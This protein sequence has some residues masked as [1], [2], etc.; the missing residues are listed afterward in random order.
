MSSLLWCHSLNLRGLMLE[1]AAEPGGQMLLMHHP[2]RDYPGLLPENGR[3]LRD[4]FENHLRQ[5]QLEWQ[6]GCD[7]KT[8]DL[9]SRTVSCNGRQ[10]SA[11]ALV[12]ATG[13]RKRRLGI[14]GEEF[15]GVSDSATRDQMWLAGREVC[16][17]GG[18]DSAFEDSLILARVCPR[19]TLVH[20]SGN[21]RARRLWL[22]EV[23]NHPRIAVITDSEVKAISGNAGEISGVIIEDRKT[24]AQQTLPVQGLVVQIGVAPQTEFLAGQL[25]LDPDGFIKTDQ[26]QRTS[27]EMV[28]ATGDVTRPVCLSVASAVGQGAIAIKDIA[29]IL[30]TTNPA[31]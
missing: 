22:D 24:R 21:F 15:K 26:R 8:V 13:V 11:Q 20:R 23:F 4:H 12:I 28:Y 6:T 5:L 16:V 25:E 29:E 19:V 18:G 7:I 30:R 1:Q 3:E 2:I 17:I 14:P 27:A 9:Q 31:A 10:L